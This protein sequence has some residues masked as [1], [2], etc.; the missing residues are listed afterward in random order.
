VDIFIEDCGEIPDYKAPA[1]L[2]PHFDS[3]MIR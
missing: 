3:K 1:E 2:V